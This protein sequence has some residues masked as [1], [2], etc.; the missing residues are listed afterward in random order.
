MQVRSRVLVHRI[1]RTI[2]VFVPALAILGAEPVQR[3]GLPPLIPRE[4]LFTKPAAMQA[5]GLSPD[6]RLVSYLAADEAGVQQ[7]WIR[8][9]ERNEARRLTSVPPP[10]V[11]SYFWAENCR[12]VCYE[13]ASGS[14][15]THLIGLDIT[16]AEERPFVA[17][18]SAQFGNL[19]ARPSVPDE[20]L[21]TIRL[22]K[23]PEND[24]YRLNVTTGTLVLDTKN[25]GGVEGNRFFADRSLRVRAAQRMTADGSAE[26]LV[27]D[28]VT[29]PWRSWLTANSTYNLQVEGFNAA[30][31]ALLL[32]SDMDD[33]TAGLVER[34]LADGVERVIARAQDLD[35]ENVLLHPRTG[36]VQA[37]S[38][39]ADPRRWEAV[40]RA[41][42]GEFQRLRRL[43][44]G[45]VSVV[46]R[47]RDDAQWIVGIS[48]DRA[49][50]RVYLWDRGTRKGTL[51][52]EEQPHL[53]TLPLARVKPIAF[54]ARDGLRIPG[55]LTLPV[56][57]PPRRLPLVVWVHGG[58]YLRDAWAYD[59][60]AQLFANR[61]YA[62]L[63]LNFRGSRGFGRH[64]RL[65]SFKQWGGTMQHDVEDAV[66]YVVRSG[67]AD[68]SRVGIIGHSYGGYVVLAA[69]TMT[70]DL[71]ACGAAS[72]T[73]ANLVAFV[74]RFPRTP[75]NVWVRE[76]IGDHTRPED[77]AALRAAS[78]ATHIERLSRPLLIARGDRDETL[79]PG[80]LEAFVSALEKRGRDVTSIVY[81]GDGHFFRRENQLDYLARVE[82]LFARCLGGS[83][84]PM[85]GD[86]YPRSTGRIRA[87][88][89]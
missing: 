85:P 88:G 43:G 33:D 87:S 74:E 13:R 5:F 1:S 71:F 78:P 35:V 22:P 20:L 2:V 47:D 49:S 65:S 55:Y 58:P 89:R 64:F 19:M 73:T 57:V 61:G 38:Y 23:T 45:H 34:R 8:D 69:L 18:E 66:A 21:L 14:S 16:T 42:A 62:F 27:R 41:M 10:G 29:K 53:S 56:G 68:P 11:R 44:S 54:T 82:A 4:S 76:T 12:I 15:S 36:A 3:A 9:V 48:S 80:D 63:R 52:F 75:D 59:Y 79:P 46:S 70:P 86:A 81:E 51:L 60:T 25:P 32:R 28:E 26:V 72:A 17:V 30:G 84:E 7:L 67:T 40:D 6:G 24:V 39:L 31:D 37:V 77:A 83:A 50:R